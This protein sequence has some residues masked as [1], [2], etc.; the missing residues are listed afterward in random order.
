MGLFF[1]AVD[2]KDAYF[3]IQIAPPSQTILEIQ[4]QGDSL[5]T[6]SPTIRTLSRSTIFFTKC[7]DVTLPP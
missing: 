1:L 7:V 3:H 2:L 6:C 5:P 4:V